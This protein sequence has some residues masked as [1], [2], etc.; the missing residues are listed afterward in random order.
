MTTCTFCRPNVITNAWYDRVENGV[1]FEGTVDEQVAEQ[2]QTKTFKGISIELNWLRPGG[3]VEFMNGVTPRN[4]ELTSVHLL[5]H[6][7][8]GDKDAYIKFWNAIVEQLVGVGPARTID[9]RVNA[10]E[11]GFREM[12]TTLE[13]ISG[14]IDVL[15][16]GA[17]SSVVPPSSAGPRIQV[18]TIPLFEAAAAKV[19][20]I[21][22]QRMTKEQ[23]L[24]KIEDLQKQVS[25]NDK[26][27]Y[28]ESTFSPEEK[29]KVRT[30]NSQL[31]TE[32]EAY[33]QALAE[34]VKL[35]VTQNTQ[36]GESEEVK[37]LKAKLA[38]AEK[39]PQEPADTVALRKDLVETQAKLT[40][41]EKKTKAEKERFVHFHEAVKGTHP[42]LGVQ[43][44]WSLGPQRMIAEQQRVL[45]EFA[46]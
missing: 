37:S 16:K 5:K 46:P 8:P 40:D 13:V 4:F 25:E 32:L 9:D 24:Q 26:K 33:R 21:R 15:G 20:D 35:E 17:A 31:Y 22:E 45:R 38:E 6:F 1:A 29:E 44:S 43:R 14:K 2:L 36:A 27:L 23:I 30:E 39:K 12:H 10:L 19:K 7:P 11:S 42:V 3:K 18:V 34:V 41:A 28:P